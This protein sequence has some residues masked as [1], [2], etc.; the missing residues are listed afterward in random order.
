M[1]QNRW[2]Q[3]LRLPIL[4]KSS[5]QSDW[6]QYRKR[7]PVL[8]LDR[9]EGDNLSVFFAGNPRADLS[10]KHYYY[11]KS[12]ISNGGA[13]AGAE[14]LVK[15]FMASQ[16]C[17]R[18]VAVLYGPPVFACRQCHQLVYDSRRLERHDRTLIKAQAI[19]MKL[20]GS[21]S[22]ADFFPPKPKGMHNRT[23]ERLRMEAEAADER[24]WPPFLKTAVQNW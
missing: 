15:F 12:Q 9:I 17:G 6:E 14:A 22:M 1:R 11:F 10:L 18:R 5:P 7:Y 4:S 19:R 8:A 21:G 16:G 23:H 2:E 3:Y 20:G 24:S 13:M